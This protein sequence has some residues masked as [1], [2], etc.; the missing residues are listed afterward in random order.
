V[1]TVLDFFVVFATFLTSTLVVFLDDDLDVFELL[2][3][4]LA[5]L[6]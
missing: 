5:A 2:E 3:S 1:R 4:L 6:T